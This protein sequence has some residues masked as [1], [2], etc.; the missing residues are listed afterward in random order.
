[1]KNVFLVFLAHFHIHEYVILSQVSESHTLERQVKEN[2]TFKN[3]Y[4]AHLH[5]ILF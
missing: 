4:F 3:I 2:K 5:I 1:M